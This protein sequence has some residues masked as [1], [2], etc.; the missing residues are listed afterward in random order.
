MQTSDT[1]EM[2]T[3]REKEWMQAW[4]DKD[5]NKFNDI[6]AD[7]FLLSSARGV[8]MTKQEWI[9]GALGPFT[10]E[11]FQWKEIKVRIYDNVA[12]VNAITS[13]KANVGEQDWSGDFIVTDV[14][15]NKNG[16]WQVV[17]RQG[18]GPLNK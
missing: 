11:G 9:K 17:A 3:K 10:C 14:W 2:I 6:L 1:T 15:V 8:L 13:Q 16:K 5:E 18:T 7:D 12:V 4:I